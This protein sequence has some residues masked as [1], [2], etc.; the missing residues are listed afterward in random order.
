MGTWNT[1]AFDNDTAMDVFNEFEDEGVKALWRVFD[2]WN[3][4]VLEPA[5]PSRSLLSRL[6]GRKPAEPTPVSAPAEPIDADLTAATIAAGEIIAA[7][8]GQPGDAKV[9]GDVSGEFAE[10]IKPHADAVR[11]DAEL[12]RAAQLRID[13][14]L[15]D[16]DRS[17]L[18]GLWNEADE[19]D[20]K[21]FRAGV[22][23]LSARLASL[24]P[25]A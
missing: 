23:D 22:A 3:P 16:T 17:E 7:A 5:A 2:Q 20:E 4:P 6:L 19:A 21:D 13:A 25:E 11:A 18:A 10:S 12:L 8:H 1:G 24:S 9:L 15:L 14:T